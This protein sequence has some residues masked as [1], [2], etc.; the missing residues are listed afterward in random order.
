MSALLGG[1]S[2]HLQIYMYSSPVLMIILKKSFCIMRTLDPNETL[3]LSL[4]SHLCP[5]F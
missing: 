4:S 5:S 1:I 3:L 2:A